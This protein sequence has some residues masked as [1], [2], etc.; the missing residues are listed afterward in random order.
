MYFH[1]N[2]L[3]LKGEPAESRLTQFSKKAIFFSKTFDYKLKSTKNQNN[4]SFLE[5]KKIW[6]FSKISNLLFI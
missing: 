4:L 6:P 3:S 2:T 5:K 1:I